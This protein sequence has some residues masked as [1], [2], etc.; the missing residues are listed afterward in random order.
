MFFKKWVNIIFYWIYNNPEAEPASS[1]QIH[2]TLMPEQP[3]PPFVP[4]Q[5]PHIPPTLPFRSKP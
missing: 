1:V 3:A 4:S 5:S 2:D